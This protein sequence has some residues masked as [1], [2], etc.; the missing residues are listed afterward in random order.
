M[1]K[2]EVREDESK[3]NLIVNK[4]ALPSTSTHKVSGNGRQNRWGHRESVI[5][6]DVRPFD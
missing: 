6:S 2:T 5:S 3:I 4:S 1:V